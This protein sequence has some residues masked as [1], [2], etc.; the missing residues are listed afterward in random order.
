MALPKKTHRLS[1][2]EKHKLAIA[3]GKKST[4]KLG[5]GAGSRKSFTLPAKCKEET[6]QR[7]SRTRVQYSSP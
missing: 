2:G 4:I 6:F 3:R 1:K 5:K 7:S